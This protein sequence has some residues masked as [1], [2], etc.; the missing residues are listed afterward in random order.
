MKPYIKGVGC[1]VSLMA[2]SCAAQAQSS[3]TL[4]GLLDTSI[5]Y[6]NT[7]GKNTTRLDSSEVQTSSWGLKG[8][9][10]IGGGTK[11]I[12]KLENG[13]NVNN[14]ANA[15]TNAMFGREAWV[16][17]TGSF[18]TITA[19]LNNTEM[20][21][22]LVHYSMGDL[23]H[24][25]WGHASNN[26]DFFA[27]TRV[28]DSINY[29]S[30]NMAGF[31]VTALYSRGANGST[32]LPSTLGDTAELGLSFNRGPLSL[33][34]IYE[35]QVY[36]KTTTITSSSPTQ[37]GNYEFFGASYDFNVV[38]LGGLVMVH[39]G[40][41]SI[42]ASNFSGFA[43]PNNIY[44]DVSALIPNVLNSN[45]SLMFS[46]GQYKLQDNSAGN[47]SSYGMRYD[48][49]LSRS[50]GVYAGVAGIKNGS[51]ASFTQTGAQYSGVPVAPGNN[52][53]AVLVGMM[54]RF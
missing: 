44:Y 54:H 40:A 5:Q 46:F 51:L 21:W 15:Q 25:D 17:A 35:S 49:H 39:R 45:G 12:F 41:G 42:T 23:G 8:Q 9:E 30:P 31:Q 26:Y 22:G 27:M 18:G 37:V 19:G 32:T 52:E 2:M 6:A 10:D 38:K 33:E 53:V 7:G 4:Y 43:D 48:Y 34:A 28:S 14:G 47:S 1:A 36:S 29:A 13:F 24:W 11:I 3:V 50:T 20:M 16:G